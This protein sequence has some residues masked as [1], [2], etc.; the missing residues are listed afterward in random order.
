MNGRFSQIREARQ[1]PRF[2]ASKNR[3]LPF[4]DFEN[5]PCLGGS[6]IIR[7]TGTEETVLRGRK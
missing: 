3:R 2:I 4:Y 5:G 7:P 1:S 6:G